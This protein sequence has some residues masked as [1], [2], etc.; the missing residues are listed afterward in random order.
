ML[1]Y[2]G[3]PHDGGQ[4]AE[5]FLT[6]LASLDGTD[7]AVVA[8]ENQSGL[9]YLLGHDEDHLVSRTFPVDDRWAYCEFVVAGLGPDVSNSFLVVAA[10]HEN[11][12][13]RLVDQDVVAWLP[14]VIGGAPGGAVAWSSPGRRTRASPW[15]SGET[16]L[17]TR[18]SIETSPTNAIGIRGA[19][20]MGAAGRV[21]AR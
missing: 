2:A 19:P 18:G 15:S 1:E 6:R 13:D 9:E 4:G 12:I 10:H 17:A 16:A 5:G 14:A 8:I 21:G 20:S 11:A 3:A 7:G